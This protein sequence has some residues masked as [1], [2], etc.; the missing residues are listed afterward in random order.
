MSG[1][2]AREKGKRGE[3][4]VAQI[5]RAALPEIAPEI[6]RGWQ[7]R[8]GSDDS[9]V[10]GLPGF[11]VEVKHQKAVNLRAAYRQARTESAGRAYPLVVAQFDHDRERLAVLS[12]EDFLRILRS[13][14][15]YAPPLKYGVQAELFE[16]A[17]P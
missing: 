12:F 13:A 4:I 8:L 15:G 11:W 2:A 1:R 3:R 7:S 17:E 14:Y 9:D 5:L 6:R 16:G 10:K